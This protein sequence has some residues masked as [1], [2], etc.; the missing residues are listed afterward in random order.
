MGGID[1]ANVRQQTVCPVCLNKKSTGLV[2][3]WKCFNEHDM[4]DG[5]ADVESI[6]HARESGLRAAKKAAKR[7]EN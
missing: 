6:L 1:N 3:C 5:N 2:V 7:G 4:R